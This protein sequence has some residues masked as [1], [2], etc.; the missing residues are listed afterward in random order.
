M[1]LNEILPASLIIVVAIIG[2]SIGA[3]VLGQIQASQTPDSA[4]ANL[5]GQGISALS[6]F[7]DWWTVIVIVVVAVIVIGLVMMLARPQQ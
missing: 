6:Q 4:E 2:V 3:Q 7:G 1:Q 5:T